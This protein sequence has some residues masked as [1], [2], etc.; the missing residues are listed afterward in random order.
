M[1]DV[2]QIDSGVQ[3]DELRVDALE[4][5]GV[6]GR[7]IVEHAHRVPTVHEASHKRRSDEPGTA[8]H[9]NTSCLSHSRPR[10]EVSRRPARYRNCDHA[11]LYRL[12]FGPTTG[13]LTPEA[14]LGRVEGLLDRG[15]HA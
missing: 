7:E 2:M 6:T 13:R 14:G 9:E 5:R 11:R 3:L 4:V 10:R 1:L 8:G 12:A 15:A